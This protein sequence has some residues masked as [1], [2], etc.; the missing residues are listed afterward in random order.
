MQWKFKYLDI[1]K[2]HNA[3]NSFKYLGIQNFLGR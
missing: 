2:K 1:R 3:I